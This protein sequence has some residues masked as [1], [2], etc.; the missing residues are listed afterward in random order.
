MEEPELSTEYGLSDRKLGEKLVQL[1]AEIRKL[2][3]E[4]RKLQKEYYSE[5][6]NFHFDIP[7]R[8][9]QILFD[10]LYMIGA[11]AW[12]IIRFNQRWETAYWYYDFFLMIVGASARIAKDGNQ[13]KI[14]EDVIILLI[15]LLEQ[16]SE[17]TKKTECSGDITSR[18]AE[19]LGTLK[20]VFITNSTPYGSESYS[21]EST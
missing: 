16:T 13:A 8:A 2:Q 7:Q 12:E 21:G 11:E 6:A 10:S 14:H 3:A 1:Q 17:M 5:E 9:D 19:A 18:N 20:N 15:D 4:I